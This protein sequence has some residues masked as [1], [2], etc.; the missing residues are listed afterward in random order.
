LKAIQLTTTGGPELLKVTEVPDPVAKAGEVVIRFHTSGVNIIDV[1]YRE[2]KYKADLPFI[3][4]GEGSGYISAVGD[5]V[6][7]F[8]VGDPVAWYGSFGSYAEFAAVKANRVVKV[9]GGVDL[10][11]AAALMMQGITAH[12]L[13]TSTFA[14]KSGDI[15][16]VHAAAGGVGYLLTQLAVIQGARV[17]ATVSSQAKA[18]LAKKAGAQDIIFYKETKFEDEVKKLTAGKGVDVVYDGVGQSTFEGSLKS[19]RPLGMLALYGASSGAVPPFDLARLAALG[20]LFVTRPVSFDYVRTRE[21]YVRRLDAI[22]SLYRDRKLSVN[23]GGVF[24]LEKAS[25]AHEELESR[26]SVGKL[27]LSVGN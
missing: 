19:L 23:I 27:R 7:G 21:E 2:G 8:S 15:A 16:L 26:R 10:P 3:P 20:S 14:L 24:P 5:G 1:Y 25:S 12:Y 4:G 17:I 22:F 11:H 6:E 9:P 18:D 13:A